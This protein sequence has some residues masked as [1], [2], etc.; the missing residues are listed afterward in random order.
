[1]PKE[2]L[3]EAST[4]KTYSAKLEI[5]MNAIRQN[6]NKIKN[7]IGNNK[8][9]MLVI[10]DNGYGTYINTQIEFLKEN[11]INHIGVAITDEGVEMRKLGYEGKILILNQ[12]LAEEIDTIGKYDLSIGVASLEFIKKLSQKN[13]DFNIHL[14]IETGMGRTGITPNQVK[15]I[16]EEAEQNKKLHIIGIY[17]HFATSDSNEEYTKKQIE[18]FEKVLNENKEKLKELKYIHVCNSMGIVDYPDAHYDM[19]R[20]GIILYGYSPEKELDEKLGFKPALKL[21]TKISF[22]K[23]VPAD[24][25]ISY[26]NTYRTTKETKIATVQIGYGDGVKRILSNKGK[27]VIKG[28]LAPIIGTIC[29][30]S[31]MVD[32]SKIEDVKVGDEVYIWDNKN[33]KLENVAKQCNSVNCEIL[34]SLS[35]RLVREYKY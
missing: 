28:E 17:T 10:K 4:I 9:I 7:K 18:T 3:K 15:E 25:Y 12:P 2:Y 33:I 1:M 21:K 14:E 5:D 27:V 13:K 29:M 23:T 22:I 16:I 32:I 35:E 6:I 11:N 8:E 19:V 31:F 30:D 24:T 20:P 34:T 26:G